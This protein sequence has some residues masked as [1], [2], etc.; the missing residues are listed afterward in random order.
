[1]R[2][3]VLEKPGGIARI[4]APADLQPARISPEGRAARLLVAGPQHDDMAA[5]ESIASIQFRIISA[6]SVRDK[7]RAQ[8]RRGGAQRAADDLFHLAFMQVEAG[9]E[10]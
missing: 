1:M 8:I 4:D 3:A 6:G 10:H 7:V 2:G 9:T 5:F